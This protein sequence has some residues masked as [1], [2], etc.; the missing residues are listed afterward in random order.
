MSA[1]A[2]TVETV[3]A[4]TALPS[5]NLPCAAQSG[6]PA[7]ARAFAAGR[8]PGA[9][10]GR[11]RLHLHAVGGADA[12]ARRHRPERYR[13]VRAAATRQRGVDSCARSA[14]SARSGAARTQPR[15]P[16]LGGVA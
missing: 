13:A 15:G 11:Q 4:Y 2:E 8:P 7:Q 1:E 16:A 9:R 12:L 3:N 14:R 10:L 5:G 6:L